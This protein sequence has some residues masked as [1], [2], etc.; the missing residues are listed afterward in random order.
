VHRRQ[1]RSDD[2]GDDSRGPTFE[3]HLTRAS[4]LYVF[5]ILVAT[6]DLRRLPLIE[7]ASLEGTG[8]L[9][10][11]NGIIGAGAEVF[12]LIEQYRFERYACK[13]ARVTYRC[14]RSVD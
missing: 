3:C 5:D 1:L 13:A 14:G 6:L 12:E 7:R 2:G 4:R 11:A 9:V 10:F 8:T